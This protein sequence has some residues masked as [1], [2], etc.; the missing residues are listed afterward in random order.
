M[1]RTEVIELL[2]KY[3]FLLN[4]E[5]ISVTKAFL[6]GSYSDDTANENSDIDIMIV[7]DLYNEQDDQIIGKIWDLTRKISTKIEPFLIGTKKF[8][9]DNT[10][11]LINMIKTKGI[12][13]VL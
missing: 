9:E 5:G 4:S 10:S 13:I 6:F 12:E 7:S 11:P 1:A 8:T 2:R 3:V